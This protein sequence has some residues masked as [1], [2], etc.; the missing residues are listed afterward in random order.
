[1]RPTQTNDITPRDLLQRHG[2]EHV[3]T[4][5]GKF[6]AKCP[7]CNGGY[8]N[9]EEKP[10]GVVWY[11]H[12]CK[13]G[14]GEP[15]EQRRWAAKSDGLGPIKA[16]FDYTDEGGKRLFQALRFEPVGKP[17]TF[18]QRTGPDQEKWSIDGVRIVPFRL[19]E[20]IEDIAADHVVVVVEGE[21]DVDTLR[22]H[23]VPATCNPMGAGKWWG[24]F[25]EIFRD[26]DV[27]ICGDNDQPGR[28]H[29]ALVAKNLHGFARRL[30]VLNL[31]QFWP[32]IEESDDVTDWFEAGGTAERLWR[33]VEQLTEWTVPVAVEADQARA[34]GN[35][36]DAGEP[37]FHLEPFDA[38]K[39]STAPNYLVKG[40]IPRVGLV[41]AW[42]PPKCGKSFW[43]FDLVMHVALGWKYRDRKVQQ[44][45]VVYCAFEGAEGFKA[46]VEAF[47][48]EHS[49]SNVPFYLVSARMDM[50]HDHGDLIGSILAQIGEQKPAVVV[51]DTLNRSMTGS[52]SSDEDMSGYVRAADAI[53]EAFNCAVLIV[54]HC[55][56]EGTRPRGHTSL[57]GAVEAQLA[58]K[59]DALGNVT[60]KVEHMKDGPE[61]AE[62]VSR[63]EPVEL[64]ADDDG[65]TITTCIVVPGEGGAARTQGQPTGAA[66]I[67]LN[68]LYN[69]LAEVGEVPPANNHIPPDTRT[70]PVELWRAHCYAGTIAETDKPDTKQKAFVRASKRLQELG[71][72]G[73]WNDQVW[74]AGHA[75]T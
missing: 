24:S 5:K 25:N 49:V 9:V 74:I 66:K 63:L 7:N 36:R 65:D 20:L 43:A 16:V 73:V 10:D 51:L 56:I 39:L 14:G 18:R 37:R 1:M 72:I 71:S 45:S 70:C 6:T 67:A 48:R 58:V 68:H 61:G 38:I 27:V 19:P 35:G 42:G 28:D 12:A 59:R 4:R 8:L 17:K 50:V 31:K 46:R 53:R 75:R 34:S 32:D 41:V 33:M 54:H 44:G 3:A 30:R 55:G 2:I 64:G 69:V 23:G 57:T 11:C 15:F 13:E 52:E 60:V 62:I 29:V 21:K 26:A 40:I 47:R 22:A